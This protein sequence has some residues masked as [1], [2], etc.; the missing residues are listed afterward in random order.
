[1]CENYIIFW[2]KKKAIF[3]IRLLR[4]SSHPKKSFPH[5]VKLIGENSEEL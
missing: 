3:V 2:L 1:M 5:K 4:E